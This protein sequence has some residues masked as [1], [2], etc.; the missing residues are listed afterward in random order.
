MRCSDVEWMDFYMIKDFLR[1]ST[2]YS[3]LNWFL[4][5]TPCMKWIHGVNQNSKFISLMFAFVFVEHSSSVRPKMNLFSFQNLFIWWEFLFDIFLYGIEY[6]K[7]K[8]FC[9]CVILSLMCTGNEKE[10]KFQNES[11]RRRRNYEEN[12]EKGSSGDWCTV[13]TEKERRQAM[14]NESKIY[15]RLSHNSRTH[16]WINSHGFW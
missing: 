5:T 4:I 16:H 15:C 13:Y 3:K 7:S 1:T 8:W 10:R 6:K 14:V 11:K 2:I 9:L 12:E